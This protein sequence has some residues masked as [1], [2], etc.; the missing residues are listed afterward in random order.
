MDWQEATK[1]YNNGLTRNRLTH[2]HRLNSR[3]RLDSLWL[4]TFLLDIFRL[5]RQDIF[6]HNMTGTGG[7]GTKASGPGRKSSGVTPSVEI[8]SGMM[9][10]LVFCDLSAGG[11]MF[12]GP[13]DGGG[14]GVGRSE[15]RSIIS[16]VPALVEVAAA[17]TRS[18][19]RVLKKKK[20]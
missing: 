6:R 11:I 13:G 5:D 8:V 15:D 20:N 7:S 18:L 12:S 17:S 10:G 19:Q 16:G 2:R 14:D 3:Y 4:I 9:S 1:F